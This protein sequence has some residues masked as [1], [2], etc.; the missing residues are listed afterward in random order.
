MRKII[1]IF[2]WLLLSSIGILAILIVLGIGGVPIPIPVTEL[3]YQ[4]PF[5]DFIGHEY[6]VIAPVNAIFWNDFPDKEKIL[7]VDLTPPPGTKN[8]FVSNSVP[9]PI[10][11]K[12]R[13]VSAW[14]QIALFDL[15]KFY[16]VLI[17]GMEFPPGAPIK[18]NVNSDGI[19]DPLI[20]KPITQ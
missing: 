16:Q 15:V 13:I 10:G 7:V 17:P 20:Y 8:R 14:R 9:L 18:M 5:S 3:T 11:Q 19:P 12:V 4:P 1:L 6:R 2:K